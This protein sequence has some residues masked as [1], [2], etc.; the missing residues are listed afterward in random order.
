MLFF[1]NSWNVVKE[2]EIEHIV[3]LLNET[4]DEEK[5]MNI[6]KDI[7]SVLISG[8]IILLIAFIA[9]LLFFPKYLYLNFTYIFLDICSEQNMKLTKEAVECGLL[10]VISI[11]SRIFVD[12]ILCVW[13]FF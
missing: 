4:T 3:A 10:K 6:V 8:F 9:V 2:G 7:L 12:P 11:K 5:C 13:L 1:I